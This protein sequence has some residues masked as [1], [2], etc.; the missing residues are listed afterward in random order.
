L[1]NVTAGRNA[2]RRQAPSGCSHWSLGHHE[3]VFLGDS[4][5]ENWF[6]V[7]ADYM[8][9]HH[10]RYLNAGVPGETTE[11]IL[12][13]FPLHVAETKPR[14]VH[15]WAGTNDI[16]SSLPIE[17]VE[18]NLAKLHAAAVKAGALSI[19]VSVLPMRGEHAVHNPSV[20]ALNAWLRKF[21]ASHGLTYLDYYSLMVDANGEL[22]ERYAKSDIH[23][24]GGGQ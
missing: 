14:I 6:F 3:I 22:A 11:E 12:A 24:G 8:A 5:T 18:S 7:D 4:L 2:G 20:V 16:T 9:A 1:G 21:A 23:I 13:R 15:I 10:Y 19:V 17:S